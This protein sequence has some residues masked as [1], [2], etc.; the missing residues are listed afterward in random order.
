M[1]F[2][3]IAMLIFDTAIYS[4]TFYAVQFYGWSPWWF[5]LSTFIAVSNSPNLFYRPKA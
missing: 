4:G 2:Y 5:L 3:Y 1:I